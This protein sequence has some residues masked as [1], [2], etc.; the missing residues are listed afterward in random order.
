MGE[1]LVKLDDYHGKNFIRMAMKL[2]ALTFVRPGELRFARWEE[3]DLKDN[4]W[5]IPGH[6]MKMDRDHVMHDL[7][8]LSK[9]Q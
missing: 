9:I 3:V 5:R 8:Y 6:R 4:L 1:F 2:L 7:F